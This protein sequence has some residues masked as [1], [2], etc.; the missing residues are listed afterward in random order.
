MEDVDDTDFYS[1][2]NFSVIVSVFDEV[3]PSGTIWE[4][5]AISNV[6]EDVHS[7]LMI[8]G[9]QTIINFNV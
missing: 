9:K 3:E 8:C 6:D 2:R 4:L 7:G 5:A 1:E